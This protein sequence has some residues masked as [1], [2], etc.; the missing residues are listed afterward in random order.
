MKEIYVVTEYWA[1]HGEGGVQPH[2]FSTYEQAKKFFDYCIEQDKASG[3][4]SS[5][6]EANDVEV[7]D[8]VYNE[9]KEPDKFY[10][11]EIVNSPQ[12]DRYLHYWSWFEK[13]CYFDHHSDYKLERQVLDEDKI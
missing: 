7:C 9:E 2:S 11:V 12:D 4:S 3:T 6:F 13:D 8:E 1:Q 5:S 10:A